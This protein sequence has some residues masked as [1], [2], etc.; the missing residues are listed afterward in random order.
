MK[1]GHVTINLGKLL[2]TK[3]YRIVNQ[4]S[5]EKCYDPNAKLKVAIDL[6]KEEDQDRGDGRGD[7]RGDGGRGFLVVS[8]TWRTSKV[9]DRMME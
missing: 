7:A 5:L 6:Q 1:I 2:N 8:S 3:T 4:Y 9:R